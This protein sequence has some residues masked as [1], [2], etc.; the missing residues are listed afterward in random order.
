[1]AKQK[2]T[3]LITELLENFLVDKDLILYNVEFIKEGK[4]W[5]LRIYLDKT[6]DEN[7]EMRYISTDECELV[8][9]WLSKELDEKDPIEQNYYLEVSSPGLDRVLVKEQDYERFKGKSVEIRLYTA[10]DGKKNLKGILHGFN[11]GMVSIALPQGD[12]MEIPFGSIAKT[13][14]EVII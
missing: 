6:E 9:R 14:L 2:V 7:G 1:M 4:D 12:I 11:G 13:K 5:F 10:I 3:E 8:S